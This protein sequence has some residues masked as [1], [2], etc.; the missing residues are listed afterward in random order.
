MEYT[1]LLINLLILSNMLICFV[2]L[3]VLQASED[4]YENIRNELKSLLPNKFED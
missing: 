4:Y 2:V 3:M 1:N